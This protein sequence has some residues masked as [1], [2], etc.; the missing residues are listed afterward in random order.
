MRIARSLWVLDIICILGVVS[1]CGHHRL[2]GDIT[3][4]S[5]EDASASAAEQ[6]RYIWLLWTNRCLS[7]NI[8]ARRCSSTVRWC[9]GENTVAHAEAINCR[10]HLWT[11]KTIFHENIIVINYLKLFIIIIITINTHVKLLVENVIK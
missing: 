9:G 6:S 2:T 5:G 11:T 10:S 8:K 7:E 4:R 3:N 1:G